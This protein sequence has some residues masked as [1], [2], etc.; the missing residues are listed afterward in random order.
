MRF[1]LNRK[2]ASQQSRFRSLAVLRSNAISTVSR[3]LGVPQDEAE[4]IVSGA[5]FESDY[6]TVGKYLEAFSDLGYELKAIVAP[7]RRKK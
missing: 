4:S 1:Q 3:M 2:P 7:A 5:S 6:S